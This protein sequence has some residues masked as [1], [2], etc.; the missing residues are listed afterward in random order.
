MLAAW[1]FAKLNPVAV[2][3]ECHGCGAV[4]GG[5]AAK[6]NSRLGGEG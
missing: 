1:I 2:C 3:P 4:F 5:K 6:K